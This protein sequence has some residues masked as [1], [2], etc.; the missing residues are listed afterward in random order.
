MA[1]SGLVPGVVRFL[2]QLPGTRFAADDPV[3]ALTFDDGPHARFTPAVLDALAAADVRATFF[4]VGQRAAPKRD[5]VRA[6]AESG[7]TLGIHGWTHTR[8]TELSRPELD[9][10]LDRCIAALSDATGETPRYVRP[11]YGHIDAG[12][13]EHLL[14]RG[15]VPVQWSIDLEDWRESTPGSLVL[16]VRKHLAPG[17]I[18]LMHDA[19][20]DASATIAA[21]PEILNEGR[22]RDYRFVPL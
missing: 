21:L 3:V 17:A 6:M 15:L 9:D 22:E 20:S 13:A 10:E 16:H 5:V 11:P 12:V 8:F 18:V 4:V 2:S 1:G 14:T 19:L 7:H